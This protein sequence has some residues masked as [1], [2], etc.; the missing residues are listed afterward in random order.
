MRQKPSEDD[1]KYQEWMNK[2]SKAHNIAEIIVAKHRN[3]AVGTVSVYYSD[4][5]SSVTNLHKNVSNN[6]QG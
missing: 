3:G 2:M 4:Q 6:Y 1:P 5:H